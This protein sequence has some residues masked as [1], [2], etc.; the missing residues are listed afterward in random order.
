MGTAIKHPV[1]DWVNPSFVIFDIWALWHSGWASECPDVKNYKWW[2]NPVWHR[3]LYSCIHMTTVGVKGLILVTGKIC[4]VWLFATQKDT[5]TAWS[6]MFCM[7]M[8]LMTLCPINT[9]PKSVTVWPLS[10]TTMMS[11]CTTRQWTSIYS[12]LCSLKTNMVDPE[13][14]SAA[15]MPTIC[16]AQ[17]HY[18]MQTITVSS[19]T[20]V[21]MIRVRET[22]VIAKQFDPISPVQWLHLDVYS[23]FIWRLSMW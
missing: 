1:P 18:W 5:S 23:D 21:C 19:H 13:M 6:E 20:T 10:E 4:K 11:G 12:V 14:S 7:V 2:L 22:H 9:S 15:I 16:S 8:D 3:M 17:E